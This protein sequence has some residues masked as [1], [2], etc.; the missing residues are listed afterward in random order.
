MQKCV[1]CGADNSHFDGCVIGNGTAF[2]MTITGQERVV[3]KRDRVD[4]Y[5]LLLREG[6]IGAR[7]YL[8]IGKRLIPEHTQEDFQ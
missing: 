5:R 8:L 6:Q 4:V 7:S 2:V 1:E 3:L